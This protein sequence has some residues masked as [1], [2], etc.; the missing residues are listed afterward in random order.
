[1]TA[2]AASHYTAADVEGSTG[3]DVSKQNQWIDRDTIVPSREDKRP[4]GSGDPRL[5]TIETVYQFA[6]TA[7]GIKLGLSAK[8]AAHAARQ[9]TAKPSPGRAAGQLFPQN[10]TLLV[11]R[12]S[13]PVVIN[14]PYH[15]DFCEL[16]DHGIGFIALDCGAICKN[17]DNALSKNNSN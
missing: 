10:R 8:H 3:I 13:G 9:F 7:A 17:V 14:A 6:F 4:S 16:S 15:A 5:M 2:K 11:V 1:M 12:S